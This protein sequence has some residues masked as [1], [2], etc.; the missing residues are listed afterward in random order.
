MLSTAKPMRTADA[1]ARA[2]ALE[3]HRQTKERKM[4]LR[5]VMHEQPGPGKT[6][7]PEHQSLADDNISNHKYLFMWTF[8]LIVS[9]FL[10]PLYYNDGSYIA[11]TLLAAIMIYSAPS[12]VNAMNRIT[13]TDGKIA[14]LT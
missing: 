4:S 11:A 7:T 2:Y 12:M 9:S 3:I 13:K 8:N 14:N 5:D 1:Q 6:K 10:A